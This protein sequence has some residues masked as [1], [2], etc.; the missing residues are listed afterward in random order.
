MHKREEIHCWPFFAS[1]KFPLSP[2]HSRR[3]A[4]GGR[5]FRSARFPGL[6]QMQRPKKN[7]SE[8]SA[9]VISSL[10]SEPKTPW[11]QP[12]LL[13][14][15][16]HECR[17]ARR[18]G[19]VGT[20]IMQSGIS[21]VFL[22]VFFCGLLEKEHSFFKNLMETRIWKLLSKIKWQGGKQI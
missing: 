16:K 6:L 20:K 19:V 22:L 21:W 17:R 7:I 18:D 5:G 3:R 10:A 9:I 4:R 13:F 11:F 8:K 12:T 14:N 2:H 15:L 1:A